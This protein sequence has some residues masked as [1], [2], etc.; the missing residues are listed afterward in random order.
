MLLYELTEDADHDIESIFEYTLSNFGEQQAF[1]Y[2]GEMENL[3]NQLCSEP[4]MGRERNEIRKG[5]RSI[6]YVSHVIFYRTVKDRIRIL[7]VMHSSRDI[8]RFL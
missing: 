4:K 5:L 3:F 2:L 6:S 7:R 8:K 1:S